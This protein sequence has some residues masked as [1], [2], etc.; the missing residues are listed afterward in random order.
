ME[1]QKLLVILFIAKLVFCCGPFG[2]QKEVGVSRTNPR[3]A[4]YS[5]P[6]A[7]GIY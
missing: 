2:N 1:T 3:R 7:I 5:K 6:G 4:Y